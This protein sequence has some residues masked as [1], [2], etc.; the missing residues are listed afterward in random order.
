[1]IPAIGPSSA[2]YP[3]S[4]LKMYISARERSFHGM[5]AMPRRPVIRPPVL[6]EISRGARFAKSFA[7]LTTLAAM[8]TET[9]ATPTPSRDTIATSARAPPEAI[10]GSLAPGGG[11]AE[12]R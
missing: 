12:V 2:E 3:I 6:N 11:V 7:G 5:I 4:Q 1:M 9:V 8:F 10:I